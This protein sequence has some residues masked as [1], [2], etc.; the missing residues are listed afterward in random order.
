MKRVYTFI[1]TL[2]VSCVL[3][4][5]EDSLRLI[6]EKEYP[7]ILMDSPARLFTMRQ[8]NES[9]LSLYRIAISGINKSVS[10]K[11][12]VYIDALASALIFIPFTHE[13]GHRSI[14]TSQRI[15][16]I[17]RPYFNKK[18][19]AYVTGVKDVDLKMLRDTD[20][21][22]Y[23]RLHTAGLESDYAMLLREASLMNWHQ[24]DKSVLYADY[25]LRKISLVSYYCYGL[26]KADVNLKEESDELKRN[27]VGH[28]VY[29]AI[30]HLHRPDMDFKRY[31]DYDDLSAEEKKFSKRVGWRSLLNLIDPLLIGKTGFML[32]SKSCGNFALGYGM[33]PF[34]D[35]IDEHFWLQAQSIDAHFYLRQYENKRTWFPALGVDFGD[36]S[37]TKNMYMDAAVHGWI[38]PKELAFNEH[39][40]KAGAAVDVMAKYRFFSRTHGLKGLSLNVGI[41]AKTLGFLLEEM[42]MGKHIGF[43]IGT[44]IWL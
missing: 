2:L 30:R 24:E 13:E 16:S 26:F 25:L 1:L 37:V 36:I 33:V 6:K 12:N 23:V 8:F 9:S 5:Q 35:Y 44:S 28:D 20:L 15:G 3:Y 40:G 38:Q 32:G 14:L 31:T 43:R 27:I 10:S 41:L 39:S 19:A 17:S 21:P 18:G 7:F 4:A 42:N 22:T 34:G 11:W 29:G